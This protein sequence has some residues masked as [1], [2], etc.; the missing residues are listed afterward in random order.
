MILVQQMTVIHEFTK[1]GTP[2]LYIWK[3]AGK[4]ELCPCRR[5]TERIAAD[6]I[7]KAV[8][9]VKRVQACL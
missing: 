1:R 2:R 4:M 7:I 6:E 8:L 3:N 5:G 9:F